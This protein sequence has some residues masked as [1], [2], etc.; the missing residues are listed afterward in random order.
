MAID[1]NAS[2]ALAKRLIS[3]NGIAITFTLAGQSGGTDYM[4][5]ESP[6]TPDTTYSGNGVFLNYTTEEKRETI[7]ET[8]DMKVLY[9]GVRPVINA[10]VDYDSDTWRVINVD[11][12]T[13]AGINIRYTIQVRK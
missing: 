7:I 6:A 8:G 5:N 9:S 10:T 3:E 1:Y 4:G 11:P 2:A 12:L 13:P